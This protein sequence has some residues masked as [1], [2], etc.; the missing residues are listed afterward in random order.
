MAN[1]EEL[2][3]TA[4]MRDEL[5]RPLEN[6][7]ENVEDVGDEMDRTQRRAGTLTTTSSRLTTGLGKL[8]G[9]IRRGLV[10]GLKAA[11]I[12]LAAVGTA[13]VLGLGKAIQL[14]MDAGETFSKFT[15]VFGK[16]ARAMD[17]WVIRTHKNFGI[18]TK[19]LRDASSTFGVFGQ[20]ADIPN[21]VLPKFS[22]KLVQAGLDLSSF[23][24]VDPGEVFMDLRSGLAGEAEP[25]RKY[26]IFLSEATLAA[27][28]AQMGL[29]GELTES[30]KVMVRQSLILAGMG[31]AEGDLA[32][33][34]DSLSNKWRALKGRA[35]ELL[36]ALGTGLMPVAT[37]VVNFLEER[38]EPITTRLAKRGW[39]ENTWGWLK[40]Q[41]DKVVAE[42]LAE[43]WERD[44]QDQV[45]AIA[46]K[47]GRFLAEGIVS[48]V[49]GIVSA[50]PIGSLV[51]LG[52]SAALVPA[53]GALLKRLVFGKAARS[54]GLFGR[55]APT[56]VASGAGGGRFG[57]P[58]WEKFA[59]P[60]EGA[61][62]A[63][64]LRQALSFLGK[65]AWGMGGA[66][67]GVAMAP[68]AP[69]MLPEKAPWDSG[70]RAAGAETATALQE[71]L[72]K[73]LASGQ[74]SRDKVAEL[75]QKRLDLL[76]RNR[77]EVNTLAG[78]WLPWSKDQAALQAIDEEIKTL[79]AWVGQGSTALARETAAYGDIVVG[80]KRAERERSDAA[81]SDLRLQLKLL[82]GVNG[83][84]TEEQQRRVNSLVVQEKF[85]KA[86]RIIRGELKKDTDAY[87]E[88]AK[89]FEYAHD[90]WLAATSQLTTE[91]DRLNRSVRAL[92][93]LP[94]DRL[95]DLIEAYGSLERAA[96][97]AA[98]AQ[99]AVNTAATGTQGA[100]GH[101]A[102]GD[103]QRSHGGGGSLANT[104][105]LHALVEAMT[106]GRRYITSAVRSWGPSGDHQA[107]R[108]LDLQGPNLNTYAANLRALGGF[109]EQHGAARGRHLHG[110]YPAGDTRSSR[111]SR[112]R[113]GGRGGGG[114]D[115]LIDRL[116]HVENLNGVQMAELED[117][118]VKAYKRIRRDN[119]ERVGGGQGGGR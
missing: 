40:V 116:V 84:L 101:V 103:T 78:N 85:G 91:H 19:D 16:N 64:G 114:G 55:G 104:L 80:V 48:G 118:V 76:V 98:Q 63:W 14:A 18:T 108:A 38:L 29:R 59:K 107:G 94:T 110:V 56:T 24:N 97:G 105:G 20:A 99:R 70:D 43:W 96:S 5:S 30:E 92:Q 93:N 74:L 119:G 52:G 106:P 46:A 4:S 112:A 51:G 10:V 3:I 73:G 111:R 35:T 54:G 47:V 13:A 1:D 8:G 89:R 12:G 61:A 42:P 28:A 44:G 7:R 11:A 68:I 41:W 26:G 115:V 31:K 95:L 27:K 9:V 65:R 22:K 15:I 60:A 21:K 100:G 102:G 117:V 69:A 50:S 36:T 87:S 82:K 113:R 2:R 109:A 57:T 49:K 32:R 83:E 86:L 45:G 77:S 71:A 62:G 34:S 23:Y 17:R 67:A 90:G 66:A 79:G 88:R 53:G 75:L 33:T 37:K 81:F 6:V 25:L 39:D 58:L 72:S